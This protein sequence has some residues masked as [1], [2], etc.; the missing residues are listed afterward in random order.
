MW[1]MCEIIVD[2]GEDSPTEQFHN[3]KAILFPPSFRSLSALDYSSCCWNKLWK[4]L[5]KTIY[6]LIWLMETPASY[7]AKHFE[8][9]LS[10]RCLLS[11]FSLPPSQMIL[12]AVGRSASCKTACTLISVSGSLGVSLGWEEQPLS[13]LVKGGCKILLGYLHFLQLHPWTLAFLFNFSHIALNGASG[14]D[15]I[16]SF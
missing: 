6:F 14:V 8:C 5:L 9:W 16:C 12:Q 7:H 3:A 10:H 13:S 15:G 1:T 2:F 4:W 11:P